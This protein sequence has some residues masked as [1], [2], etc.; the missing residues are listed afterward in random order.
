MRRAFSSA[1]FISLLVL[2]ACASEEDRTIYTQA[3]AATAQPASSG[4]AYQ[5]WKRQQP[6]REFYEPA[7]VQTPTPREPVYR[8]VPGAPAMAGNFAPA[9]ACRLYET[10]MASWYGYEL[11]GNHTANGEKFEPDG[12]T[13]AHKTLPFGTIV[14]VTL[15]NGRGNPEGVY[16]RINDR[17]PFVKGRIIDLSL[18][19]AKKLGMKDTQNVHV[20][21]C[22]D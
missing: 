7:K 14:R 5:N 16:A 1:F 17:G 8:L 9:P 22:K 18:G 10:G 3:P 4:P 15:D 2:S 20:Y 12:L 21:I 13:A 11:Y 6:V 19:S